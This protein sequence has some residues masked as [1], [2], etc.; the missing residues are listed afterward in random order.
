MILY[1]CPSSSKIILLVTKYILDWA[2][3]VSFFFFKDLLEIL[4]RMMKKNYVK[5]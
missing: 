3:T 4:F 5:V 1:N 2:E